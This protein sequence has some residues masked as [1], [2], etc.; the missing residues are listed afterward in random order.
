MSQLPAL[1]QWA[2]LALIIIGGF[3]TGIGPGIAAVGVCALLVG[4]FNEP[5]R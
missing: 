1:A 3:L 5:T 4:L 2:G